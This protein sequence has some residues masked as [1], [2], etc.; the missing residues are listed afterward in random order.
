MMLNRL[1][2]IEMVI[3]W[4]WLMPEFSV[5]GLRMRFVMMDRIELN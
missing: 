3:D 5:A 2:G 1:T 4:P